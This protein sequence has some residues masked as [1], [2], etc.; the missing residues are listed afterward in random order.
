MVERGYGFSYLSFAQTVAEGCRGD[1]SLSLA[2][3]SG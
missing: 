2:G 3:G 1:E